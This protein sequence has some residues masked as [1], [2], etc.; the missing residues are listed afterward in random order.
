MEIESVI[1][2]PSSI[3]TQSILQINTSVDGGVPL[4]SAQ[5]HTVLARYIKCLIEDDQQLNKDKE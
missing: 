2:L 3:K 4:L 1:I 5:M